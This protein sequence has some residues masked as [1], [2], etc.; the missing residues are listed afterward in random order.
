MIPNKEAGRRL[1][2]K[3]W[4]NGNKLRVETFIPERAD[5]L[6][7]NCSKWGHTNFRCRER[8]PRYV[9]CAGNTGYGYLIPRLICDCQFIASP[10]RGN[11]DTHFFGSMPTCSMS[12][13]HIS[14]LT[15][16]T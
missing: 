12:A 16:I 8:V 5:A 14:T 1:L 13:F 7:G 15:F 2:Q 6:W 4:V 11:S 10:I 3:I 9:M